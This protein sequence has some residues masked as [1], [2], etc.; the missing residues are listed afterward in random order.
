MVCKNISFSHNS[1][2]ILLDSYLTLIYRKILIEKNFHQLKFRF[3]DYKEEKY[4]IN[5]SLHF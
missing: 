4:M 1:L 3:L 2:F 5:C